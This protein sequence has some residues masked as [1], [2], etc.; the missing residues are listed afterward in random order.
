MNYIELLKHD[1]I[2]IKHPK[3]HRE[4]KL[5]RII[6][7]RSF[8]LEIPI[9]K[10]STEGIVN[11][12]ISHSF[13][14]EIKTYHIEQYAIGGYIQN[15]SNIDNSKPIWI[16]HNAK[17]FD[18]AYISNS[19]IEDYALIYGNSK[20]S[21]SHV[22][23]YAAIKDNSI[24]LNSIITGMASIKGK[25]NISDSYAGNSIVIDN[26][27]AITSS[28]ISGGSFIVG[29]N[30]V[31]KCRLNDYSS[32]SGRSNVSNC[33]LNYRSNIIDK[34][35]SNETISIDVDLNITSDK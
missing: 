10:L 5:Y 8:A 34:T 30:I 15:L 26:D 29:N 22:Y 28:Y 23:N 12:S 20:I 17:I 27:G 35:I 31:Q 13:E 2:T 18:N 25:S 3:T 16:D 19:L 32:I 9:L 24:I 4:V 21:G 1:V 7:N 6:S 11:S 14:F 33:I